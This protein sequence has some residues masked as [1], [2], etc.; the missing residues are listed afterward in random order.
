MKSRH[1]NIKQND[2]SIPSFSHMKRT[3]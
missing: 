1:K 3:S 2:S